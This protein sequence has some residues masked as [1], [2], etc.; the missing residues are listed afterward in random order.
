MIISNIQY[1]MSLDISI[2]RLLTCVSIT[3]NLETPDTN[4]D[5][6]TPN[7]KLLIYTVGAAKPMVPICKVLYPNGKVLFDADLLVSKDCQVFESVRYVLLYIRTYVLCAYELSYIH[8]HYL[9]VYAAYTI[10]SLSININFYYSI[11]LL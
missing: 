1:A 4:N 2:P 7:G 11:I 5:N 9:S 3:T 6:A 8:D 10:L